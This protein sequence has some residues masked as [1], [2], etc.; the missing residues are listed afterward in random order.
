MGTFIDLFA[1]CGGL[2]LGL[3]DSG[4]TGLFAI[5]RDLLAFSTLKA[6]L[7]NSHR[8]GYRWPKWLPQ[9]PHDIGKFIREYRT[10]LH[11]LR[12]QVDLVAGGPPC[13]GF[14]LSGR[15]RSNDPRNKLFLKYLSVVCLVQPKIILIENVRGI[16]S[17]FSKVPGEL[18][19]VEA[20]RRARNA[21]TFSKRIQRNL[22][23]IGYHTFPHL[24]RAV[25]F[26]VP[27]ERP[28]F[29]M[30][31][32]RKNLIENEAE[33]IDPFTMVEAL[34]PRFL[35]T[36]GLQV[37]EKVS[38][39]EAISDLRVRGSELVECRDKKGYE[40]IAYRGP[41]TEYQK[42]LHGKMNGH[43][44]NS[45]RLAKHSD[46]IKDRFAQIVKGARPGISLS[47]AER[48]RFG[49][50]KQHLV[51]LNANNPAH[52]LTTLPD[53]YLHYAEPRILTVREYARLQSFPDCFSFHGKYTTGGHLRAKQCP[54]Y[55]QVGN[56]VPP[57]LARFLGT[58][59][60]HYVRSQGIEVPGRT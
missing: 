8:R 34:R 32:I 59:I 7:L 3:M 52:T 30:I 35:A 33:V 23:R 57:R 46:P 19:S 56:A 1:G 45:L 22:E 47:D 15:R 39:R 36:F 5:E 18:K 12:G 48:E 44:P 11:R 38:V 21:G 29:F 60:K 20:R 6:N 37:G 2:S 14:S 4:W 13:Q 49:V 31:G 17:E 16:A 53:D 43:A 25:D 41:K 54:R 50:K 51:V 42:Q 24:L 26:G 58:L 28:R 10:E 55:T 27:Q 40:E 9:E